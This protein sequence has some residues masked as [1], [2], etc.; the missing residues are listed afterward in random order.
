MRF[1]LEDSDGPVIPERFAFKFGPFNHPIRWQIPVARVLPALTARGL[2]AKLAVRSSSMISLADIVVEKGA[3]LYA[4]Q[5]NLEGGKFS[6][7]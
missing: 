3:T 5:L 6:S 7:Q 4:R 1:Y 2:I